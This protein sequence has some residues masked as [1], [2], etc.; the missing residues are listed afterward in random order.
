MIRVV[1]SIVPLCL[2]LLAPCAASA[3]VLT[4]R[5]V[6][7]EKYT[8]SIVLDA[9]NGD[10]AAV[11]KALRHDPDF[12]QWRQIKGSALCEASRGGHVDVVRLLLEHN[13]PADNTRAPQHFTPLHCAAEKGHAPIVR[14]LLERKPP[15]EALSRDSD[16]PL[17]LA[18]KAC[19]LETLKL[20]LDAGAQLETKGKGDQTALCVAVHEGKVDCITELLRRGAS[21]AVTAC[22]T[23][24]S[25]S[26]STP[27]IA[28]VSSGPLEVTK[29]LL[30][31]G[32][33]PNRVDD[34]GMTALANAA[35][36]GSKPLIELLLAAKA[37]LTIADKEGRTPLLHAAR[38]HQKE[39]AMALLAA[40][41]DPMIV[42]NE[43]QR[44]I[45]FLVED[46]NKNAP[47]LRPLLAKYLNKKGLPKI[48]IP[49]LP[50]K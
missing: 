46:M 38:D 7:P 21:S 33:D 49:P 26:R 45:D 23:G 9:G 17:M 22:S 14:L 12:A 37:D 1:A 43:R 5:Y 15:L 47:E 44:A 20:L 2:M 11:Q 13:A 4:E 32:A 3:D 29:A 50:R 18:A 40:G 42:S 19:H 34:Q 35:R 16:T 27:L 25:S 48:P 31:G 36:R 41:A 6:P 24:S 28:A 8:E 10:L 39:A 30:D